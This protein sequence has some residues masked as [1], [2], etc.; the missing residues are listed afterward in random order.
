MPFQVTPLMPYMV[1]YGS[2][3]PPL[4][5]DRTDG[6]HSGTLASRD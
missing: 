2:D 1:R 3:T 4:A 5:D 6:G